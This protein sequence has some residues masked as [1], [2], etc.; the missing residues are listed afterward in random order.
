[1]LICSLPYHGPLFAAKR[2]P[3][4]RIQLDRRLRLLHDDDRALLQRIEALIQ[5]DQIDTDLGDAE[6]IRRADA[7]MAELSDPT[8]RQAVLSRLELRTA[9][10]ALRRRH[11]GQGPPRDPAKLGYGRYVRRICQNWEQPAFGLAHLYHWL[12]DAEAHLADGDP[13][14]LEKLLLHRVWSGL[15]RLS[16]GHDFDFT[17]VVL[18]V[19]RWD[20]ID[21]WTRYDGQAATARYD[22]LLADALGPHADLFRETAAHG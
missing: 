21:R 15:G 14:S 20:V 10:A 19:L 18:Y 3:L 8:L 4:S 12:P 7:L 13:L 6:L 22:S 5:W 17:A 16:Q 9:V 2:T 1:M 11:L